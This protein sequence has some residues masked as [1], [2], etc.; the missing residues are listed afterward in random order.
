MKRKIEKV[1]EKEGFSISETP[2]GYEVSQYTPAGEDWNL[3][4]DKLEDIVQYAENYDPE[5]D[6]AMWVEAKHSGV[7]GVPSPA[8]LWQ[9]QLWKQETL[10]RIKDKLQ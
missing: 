7:H 1:I 3:Y 9:D 4:F 10:N 5:E 8:E 2:D 6:F